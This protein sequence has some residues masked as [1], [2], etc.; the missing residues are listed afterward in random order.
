MLSETMTR[1][2]LFSRISFTCDP[3]LPMMMDASWVTIKHRMCMFA[4]GTVDDDPDALGAAEVVTE[5]PSAAASPVGGASAL[6][7]VDLLSASGVEAA[8]SSTAGGW[9]MRTSG[10]PATDSRVCAS[11][12]VAPVLALLCLGWSASEGE[13]DRLRVVSAS[14][15]VVISVFHSSAE[16]RACQ[17]CAQDGRVGE[18]VVVVDDGWVLEWGRV[19]GKVGDVRGKGRPCRHFETY[20]L[21]AVQDGGRDG[22]DVAGDDGGAE[23]AVVVISDPMQQAA[24]FAVRVVGV[25]RFH[26][27]PDLPSPHLRLNCIRIS[28]ATNAT[29]WSINLHERKDK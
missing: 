12:D 7:A 24:A 3:P 5:E 25:P 13:R 16:L 4:A 22:K 28:R 9:S 23:Q 29:Q 2:P 18:E 1:A 6:A 19:D 17:Q 20:L 26:H 27:G 10:R 15:M 11:S 8:V 14:G 21:N